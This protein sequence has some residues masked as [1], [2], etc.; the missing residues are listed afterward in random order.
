MVVFIDLSVGT[1][2]VYGKT[3][4]TWRRTSSIHG[5]RRNRSLNQTPKNL[6]KILERDIKHTFH[7]YRYIQWIRIFY[8]LL[9]DETTDTVPTTT[10]TTT[11]TIP[12]SNDI[13]FPSLHILF[14]SVAI[15]SI[16]YWWMLYRLVV[17]YSILLSQQPEEHPR[18]S[19]EIIT[20]PPTVS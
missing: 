7:I 15:G 2:L 1:L 17:E 13:I 10:T 9:S 16:S 4:H 11:T 6:P 12:T 19:I 5:F 20:A 18:T 14:V 8:T 3:K